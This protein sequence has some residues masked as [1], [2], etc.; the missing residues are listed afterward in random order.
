MDKSYRKA[1]RVLSRP[2]PRVVAANLAHAERSKTARTEVRAMLQA[3][4]D[5]QALYE[6]ETDRDR[7]VALLG[8]LRRGPSSL[9]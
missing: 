3:G 5:A 8:V 2:S 6:A 9:D 7:R 1:T 4:Q